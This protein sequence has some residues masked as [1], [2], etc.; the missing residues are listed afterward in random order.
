MKLR[1][2]KTGETGELIHLVSINLGDFKQY[3][4][5]EDLYQEWEKINDES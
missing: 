2:K 3:K 5:L 4:T 1:N